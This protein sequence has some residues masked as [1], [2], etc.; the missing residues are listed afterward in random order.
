MQISW[1]G[2]YSSILSECAKDRECAKTWQG[3]G[4]RCRRC[5]KGTSA[6]APVRDGL[7][8]GLD[9][10]PI[11]AT[12]R[13]RTVRISSQA[14]HFGEPRYRFRG[15]R[16]TFARPSIDF[17]AGA[18]FPQRW[19]GCIANPIGT[20]AQG[21]AALSHFV[22][23]ATLSHGRVRFR[24]RR[25]TFARS[26]TDFVAGAALSQ[27]WIQISLAGAILSQG[28]VQILWQAQ[29]FVIEGAI[30]LFQLQLQNHKIKYTSSIRSTLL[31]LQV[32]N[33][34]S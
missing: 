19:H 13:F 16:N 31:Q 12:R 6:A 9:G 5:A 10:R 11:T 34:K 4:S 22:A 1:Q 15:R 26:G 17:V 7:G 29:Y 32:E 28:Q 30:P 2:Q 33:R 25:S 14:Q 8:T 23:G 21:G 27:G 24:G 20:G 18:A 3:A